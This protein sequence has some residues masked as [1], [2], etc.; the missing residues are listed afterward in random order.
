MKYESVAFCLACFFLL[1]W[2]FVIPD[3]NGDWKFASRPYTDDNLTGCNVIRHIYIYI[4]AGN[5][6]HDKKKRTCIKTAGS[7][8]LALAMITTKYLTL[9]YGRGMCLFSTENN[10]WREHFI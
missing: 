9:D 2:I 3:M 4:S 7:G 5:S 6:V 10:L 1:V 8:W